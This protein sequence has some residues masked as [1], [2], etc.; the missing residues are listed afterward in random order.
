MVL[1]KER[2]DGRAAKKRHETKAITGSLEMT[3]NHTA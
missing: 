2:K 1:V 3:P